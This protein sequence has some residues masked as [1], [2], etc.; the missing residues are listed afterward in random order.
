MVLLHPLFWKRE[1]MRAH[2]T[3]FVIYALLFCIAATHAAS[4][5]VTGIEDAISHATDEC[6][7]AVVLTPQPGTEFI[8]LDI[9]TPDGVESFYGK[10]PRLQ[11]TWL[12]TM[13]CTPRRNHASISSSSFYSATT[14]S[15]IG[16][17]WAGYQI[18]NYSRFVQAGWHEPQVILPKETL[19]LPCGRTET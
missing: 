4:S 7:G 5:P 1:F 16:D 10:A 15:V 12:D 19:I 18:S 8:P 6:N 9:K 11:V 2:R 13:T 14:N 3:S 17:N